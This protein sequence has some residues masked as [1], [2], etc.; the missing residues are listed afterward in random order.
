MVED[1]TFTKKIIIDKKFTSQDDLLDQVR[2]EVDKLGFSIVITKFDY[3]SNYK[4]HLI[5][6]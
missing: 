5:R 2:C 6:V 1:V 3:D 4:P